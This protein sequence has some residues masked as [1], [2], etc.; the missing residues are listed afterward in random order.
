MAL[1]RLPADA[2]LGDILETL[3]EDGGLIIEG[4][5][6]TEVITQLRESITEAENSFVPGG[7]THGL[8]EDGKAFVGHATK[9]EEQSTSN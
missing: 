9:F 5:F 3:D 2:P 1:G 6:P 4:I 7:A 8:G